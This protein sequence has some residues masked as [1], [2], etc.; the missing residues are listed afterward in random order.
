MQADRTSFAAGL[1]PTALGVKGAFFFCVI[2]LAYLAA[3]YLNLFFLLLGFLCVLGAL[4]V[5]WT[6]SNLRGVGLEIHGPLATAEGDA[7]RLH[8]TTRSRKR[9]F[10]VSPIARIDQRWK[11]LRTLVTVEPGEHAHALE[12][13]GW[14]RGVHQVSHWALESSYP[15]GLLRRRVLFAGPDEVIVYPKPGSLPAGR[16]LAAA[17]ASLSGDAR[18]LGGEPEPQGLRP[19]RD[20]DEMRDVHWRASARSPGL[21]VVERAPDAQAGGIEVV[22][23]RRCAGPGFDEALSLLSAL[24][25]RADEQKSHLTLRSQAFEATFGEGHRSFLDLL[26][27]LA[28]A[29]PLEGDGAAPPIAAP[30]AL[31]L[32][33]AQPAKTGATAD[34]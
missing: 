10:A 34:V 31:R 21:V 25:L 5:P 11:V 28:T 16:P 17:A 33:R 7:L 14:D 30:G 13:E 2:V 26:R 9:R 6:W 12:L 24:A 1:A 23:D 22:F 29:A 27:W 18:G 20:G 32:P 4:A 19:W 15:L 8:L 3:P